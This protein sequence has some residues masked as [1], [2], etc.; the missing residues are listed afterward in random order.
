VHGTVS[1]LRNLFLSV[2][3]SRTLGGA[4]GFL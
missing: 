2:I 1:P 4:V 3:E